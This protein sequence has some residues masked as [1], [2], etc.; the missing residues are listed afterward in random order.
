MIIV[1]AIAGETQAGVYTFATGVVGGV[2]VAAGA[3]GIVIFPELCRMFA[4]EPQALRNRMYRLFRSLLVVGLLA[5]GLVALSRTLVV[6]LYGSLPSYAPDVLLALSLGLIP[7]FAAVGANYMFTAI[8]QQ[9]EG[10]FL[11]AN[12]FSCE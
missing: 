10:L 3:I 6:N 4:D 2:A 11:A 1:A 7:T 12:S 5:F 9:R 8:G